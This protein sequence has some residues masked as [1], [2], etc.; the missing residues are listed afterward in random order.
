MWQKGIEG[1]IKKFFSYAIL[2]NFWFTLSIWILFIRAFDISYTQIGILEAAALV[3]ILLLELPS[4]VFSDLFGHRIT[5]FIATLLWSAGTFIVG[6]G[7]GFYIFLIGYSILGMSDAFRSG[8][9]SALLF[10]SLRKQKRQ[11]DYLKIRSKLRKYVTVTVIIGAL[12][13][14]VLFNLNI[15]LPFLINATLI[16]ASSFIVFSMVEP[17]KKRKTTSIQ[18]HFNHFK[19][20][21]NFSIQ[22]KNVKWLIIFGIIVTI[23]MGVFVNLLSQPYLIKIGFN[24]VNIGILFAAIHGSSGVV[25]S[26]ADKI[27]EKI[28]EKVSMVLIILVQGFAFVFMAILNIPLAAIAVAMLYISR[29]YKGMILDAY[30]NK[31]INPKNRATVLSISQFVIDLFAAV[32]VIVGGY[33][34]DVFSME[35][36]IL[37]LGIITL[38]FGITH[39]LKRYTALNNHEMLGKSS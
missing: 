37:L 3:T 6:L 8:S 14:P 29:D 10:E 19:E 9:Q 20:S 25:A 16:L 15:R 4:G 7:N 39:F 28:R 2:S 17:Y 31:Q 27:E 24:V 33:I 12:V 11:K 32:F 30:M 36:T 22:H 23:P 13:G 21:L 18:E 26:F 35:I 5:V 34:T 1:N 38:V